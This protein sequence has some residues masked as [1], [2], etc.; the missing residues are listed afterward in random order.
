[1]NDSPDAQGPEG[2]DPDELALRG[3][4]HRA[5]EEVEPRDGT[6]DHLRRAVPARR[7]RK[8]HAAV[9]MAAAA[10]FLGTAVPALV[11]VS[12]TASDTGTAMAGQA[13][14]ARGGTGHGKDPDGGRG[15]SG[16][17]TGTD[18]GRDAGGRTGGPGGGGSTA[19][20]GVPGDVT[21]DPS[22][23]A[24][25]GAPMCTAAQ[26][27]AATATVGAPD[28]SGAVYGAF[29]ITNVSSAGCTVGGP[30]TVT[31]RAQGAA[32]AS[33][34]SSV[35][36]TDGDAAAGLPGL[37]TEVSGLVLSPGTAYE[38]KFAWVP[39]E[40][41]PTGGGSG[42]GGT[43]TGGPSPDPSPS[44]GPS[45]TG[46]PAAAG[47]GGPAPQLVREEAGGK[48]EGSVLVSHTPEAGS[49]AVSVTVPD[50]CAGTVYRTGVLATSGS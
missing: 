5:V 15:P 41:C 19:S 47:D 8:R 17:A 14:R 46:G 12:D 25:T 48:P 6:L 40:S 30:G 24:R 49:P 16:G 3:M 26:L 21:G 4:L 29:H 31:V 42:G 37:S 1:M 28:A 44:Q 13:T 10:L 35:Q 34:V 43:E 23:S 33:R 9:G 50:A 11:H 20:G 39:A 45:A 18:G 22:A 32:D 7:A 2:L 36:H 27:G 38:V